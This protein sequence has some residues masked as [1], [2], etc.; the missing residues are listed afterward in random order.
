MIVCVNVLKSGPIVFEPHESEL[1]IGSV[2]LRTCALVHTLEK[3]ASKKY[4]HRHHDEWQFAEESLVVVEKAREETDR[5][6]DER[7]DC[8]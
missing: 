4:D 1:R 6:H 7:E 3:H 8:T 2:L 5:T